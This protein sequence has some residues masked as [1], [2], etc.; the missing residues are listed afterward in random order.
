MC[1]YTYYARFIRIVEEKLF[2][3]SNVAY[4]TPKHTLLDPSS[5]YQ[6]PVTDVIKVFQINCIYVRSY[7]PSSATAVFRLERS[8]ETHS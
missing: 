3:K 4:T 8:H 5:I 2:L 6:S 1:I 7:K